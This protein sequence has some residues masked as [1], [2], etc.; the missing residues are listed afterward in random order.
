MP[1]SL[2]TIENKFWNIVRQ[3]H[4]QVYKRLHL[5]LFLFL[6]CK[7][8]MV[9]VSNTSVIPSLLLAQ[10]STHPSLAG[11]STKILTRELVYYILLWTLGDPK[12]TI[13]PFWEFHFG[14][15]FTPEVTISLEASTDLQLSC[16]WWQWIRGKIL[17]GFKKKFQNPSI[18]SR[19]IDGP[20]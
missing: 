1:S 6:I 18:I 14:E 11:K 10:H 12:N 13:D 5:V 17:M 19:V 3:A 15:I 2:R 16:K 20:P 7:A 4:V 8:A 9:A